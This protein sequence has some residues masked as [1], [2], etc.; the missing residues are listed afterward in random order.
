VSGSG[1]F[2]LAASASAHS[3]GV[4]LTGYC[5]GNGVF[6]VGLAAGGL[7]STLQ[8]LPLDAQIQDGEASAGSDLLPDALFL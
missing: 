7:C 6:L 3:A 1:Q 8:Y 2:R 4:A 5:A